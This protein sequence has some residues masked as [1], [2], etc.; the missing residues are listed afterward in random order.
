M[1]G[2]NRFTEYALLA[3]LALLWG[4]SYTMMKVAVAEIPPFT[5]IASRVVIAGALLHLV[6]RMQG[7]HYPRD[8]NTR[9]QLLVQSFFN[10]FGAWTV[11]AW[12]Q[13]HIDSAMAA[14]LNSTS[15]LFVVLITL[16]V[17]KDRSIPTRKVAGVVLG[18]IGVV[19]IIGIDALKGLG[20]Q[21]F[22]QLAALG[23]AAMYA[24]AALYGKRFHSLPASVTAAAT[25]LWAAL[26]MVPTAVIIDKPW[27]LTPSA[28]AVLAVIGMSVFSTALALLIYF[29][30][31]KTLGSIGTTS[32]A[33]LRAGVGVVL[34]VVLLGEQITPIVAIGLGL[35]LLGVIM[36][37]Y[38]G[39]LRE[40]HK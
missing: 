11:L 17:L 6:V 22:G 3:L 27:T 32:Q 16:I 1:R 23:G 34:G 37:N 15:P 7:E 36:I 13:Q 24:S 12:G 9:L 14:V 31:L 10:S 30:L 4:S 28:M 2:V 40:Q 18:L 25:I 35:A 21:V 33:Y 29:R 19:L 8:T 26:I 20:T 38:P 39:R 5:L